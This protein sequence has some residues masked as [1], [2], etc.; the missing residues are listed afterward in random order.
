MNKNVRAYMTVITK[1]VKNTDPNSV[2][3]APLNKLKAIFR[4]IAMTMRNIK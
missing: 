3:L 4:K 1:E 2:C